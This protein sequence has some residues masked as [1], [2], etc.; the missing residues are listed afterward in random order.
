MSRFLYLKIISLSLSFL[1]TNFS[2]AKDSKWCDLQGVT[3]PYG[4]STGSLKVNCSKSSTA[5]TLNDTASVSSITVEFL[6]APRDKEGP[7]R[8]SVE[9]KDITAKDIKDYLLHL[10]ENPGGTR[11][12]ERLKNALG[13]LRSSNFNILALEL[14]ANEKINPESVVG[15]CED[16]LKKIASIK[17][18]FPEEQSKKPGKVNSKKL[19]EILEHEKKNKNKTASEMDQLR[20]ALVNCKSGLTI[21]KEDKEK[22]DRLEELVFAE[23]A[24]GPKKNNSTKQRKKGGP[25]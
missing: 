9:L 21:F 23:K 1:F 2:Y 24:S 18:L 14:D 6:K 13:D 7:R 4:K 8:V 19:I 15:S 20:R 3:A 22:L 11:T 25:S 16:E 5:G 12:S 17:A 10:P